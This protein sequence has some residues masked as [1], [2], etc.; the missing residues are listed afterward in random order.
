MRRNKRLLCAPPPQ[1]TDERVQLTDIRP[2]RW[3]QFRVAAINVHG[4]RGFTAPSK[5]FHS[6]KGQCRR[7]AGRS[8]RPAGHAGRADSQRPPRTRVASRRPAVR[9]D[10]DGLLWKVP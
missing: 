4:T 9:G 8:Q 1:T 5:H 3:Y 7:E 2:G 10:A 6:S